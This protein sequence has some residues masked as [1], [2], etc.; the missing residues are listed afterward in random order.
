M[1]TGDGGCR[2]LHLDAA[3]GDIAATDKAGIEC[4]VLFVNIEQRNIVGVA[5]NAH[6]C[7]LAGSVDDA[8]GI[9]G[10]DAV[11]VRNFDAFHVFF[12]FRLAGTEGQHGDDGKGYGD[13]VH[14]GVSHVGKTGWFGGCMVGWIEGGGE[15]VR[16]GYLSCICHFCLQTL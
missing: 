16:C 10:F 14:D 8:D 5:G 11:D 6:T 12:L 13:D 2:N 7:F 15:D 1:E 4:S 3:D 9:G